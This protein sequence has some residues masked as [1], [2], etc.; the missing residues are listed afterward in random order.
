M[1]AALKELGF[2]QRDRVVVVHADDIGM[3]H[4]TLA[5]IEELFA[6]G[7][8]T[9]ASVM[10]PCPWFAEVAAWRQSHLDADLG[11]HLTLTSEFSGYR[12]GPVST[13]S[14][15]SGLIDKHGY[16][17]STAAAVRENATPASVLAEMEAQI[18]LAEKSGLTPSHL[19]S[20]MYALLCDEYIDDYVQLGCDR[21]IPVFLPRVLS[22][23]PGG[24]ESQRCRSQQW[25]M[26]GMPVFDHHAVVTRRSR[27][28]DRHA[29][30]RDVFERLPAGLSCVLLHP[31]SDSPEL[32]HIT[33]DWKSRV[34]DF[35]AFR[36]PA[37]LDFV[38][39]LGMHLISY[40][41]LRHAMRSRLRGL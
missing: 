16:L 21:L 41:P 40:Q 15:G 24:R 6:I 30:V 18:N 12:W 19:D 37:L 9:S 31:V 27:I 38:T 1:N 32:V 35:E 25:E 20:H 2:S 29:L 3:C 13:R 5:A 4:G 23:S 22:E 8:V 17:H 39:D 34:A 7:V 33:P 36:D 10:V 14:P 11:I 26:R 28:D